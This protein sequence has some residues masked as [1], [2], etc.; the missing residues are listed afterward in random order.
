MADRLARD[1]AARGIV[2]VSGLARGI[3]AIAHQGTM[4][5]N[6][7]AIGVLGTGVD[8]CYPKENKKLYEKVLERGAILRNFRWGR[9]RRRKIFRFAIASWRACRWEQSLSR[10]RNT[11][12]R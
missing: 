5:A 1:L 6:G 7:R 2:I 8:V 9:I 3:D 11:Q 4:T 10:A 12:A